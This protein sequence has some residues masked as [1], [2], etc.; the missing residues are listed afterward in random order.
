MEMNMNTNLN[1]LA[2]E[3]AQV[4]SVRHILNL[5]RKAVTQI[6]RAKQ[7]IVSEFRDR[8]NEHEHVLE[9]AVNEA[10]ALAWQTDYPHLLFPA[11]AMEKAQAVA[12]WQRRQWFFRRTNH[13]P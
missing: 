5:C 1:S 13:W 11:L 7:S 10:E 6:E 4:K 8:F 12:D 2:S 9:L 3:V